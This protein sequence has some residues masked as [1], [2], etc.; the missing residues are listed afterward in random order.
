MTFLMIPMIHQRFGGQQTKFQLIAIKRR[1]IVVVKGANC[2]AQILAWRYLL[3][4][5]WDFIGD[6]GNSCA[7]KGDDR[8]RER[9]ERCEP[10]HRWRGLLDKCFANGSGFLA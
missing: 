9:T 2:A 6:R 5:R 10:T 7:S 8:G 4:T 1:A 3:I